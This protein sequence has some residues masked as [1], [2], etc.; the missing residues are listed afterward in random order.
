MTPN[1]KFRLAVRSATDA[2]TLA[3]AVFLAGIDQAAD[4]PYFVQGTKGFGQRV[5]TEYANIATNVMIGGTIL[6]TLFHQ[7]PRYFYQ[8]TGSNRSRLK[9]A[10]AAPFVARGDNDRWQPNYSS[11]GGHLASNAIANTYY[12]PANRGV[13]LVLGNAAI[14]TAGSMMNAVAQE[15]LLRKLTTH[16]RSV[17]KAELFA[18]QCHTRLTTRPPIQHRHI[19]VMYETLHH[20]PRDPHPALV[21]SASSGLHDRCRDDARRECLL[22]IHA[23]PLRRYGQDGLLPH[24][25]PH[26][27]S[28]SARH[29]RASHRFPPGR[30]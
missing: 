16:A 7:A 10:L 30:R 14:S 11:L 18:T 17:S 3:S 20:L 1:L 22:Q 21:G 23:G 27:L 26:R 15:I 28:S 25:G 2:V 6:P 19:I 24:R 8:G 9:H 5:G 4:T 13:S 12:P 29:R